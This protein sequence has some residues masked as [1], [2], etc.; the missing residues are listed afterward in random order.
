M[1]E[2]KERI[3]FERNEAQS[4]RMNVFID[5]AVGFFKSELVKFYKITSILF[6]RHLKNIFY[7]PRI[8]LATRDKKKIKSDIKRLPV[9][10]KKRDRI[11]IQGQK[12]RGRDRYMW[13]ED[14]EEASDWGISKY[15]SSR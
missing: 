1:W 13:V 10:W 15:L 9:I 2:G 3:D 6:N 12:D 14:Q 7:M 11:V 8:E 5:Q 4:K